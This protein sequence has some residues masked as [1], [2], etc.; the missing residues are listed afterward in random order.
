MYKNSLFFSTIFFFSNAMS[1]DTKNLAIVSSEKLFTITLKGQEIYTTNVKKNKTVPFNHNCW[2]TIAAISLPGNFIATGSGTS[3]ARLFSRKEKKEI[4][5][6]ALQSSVTALAFDPYEKHLAIASSDKK[7]HIF[8]LITHDKIT[9]FDCDKNIF[10]IQFISSG[11][12]L[13]AE[14]SDSTMRISASKETQ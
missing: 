6:F 8:N 13:K 14:F 5:K 12:R 7:V 1:M 4:K 10:A 2:V 11:N 9:S 3:Q